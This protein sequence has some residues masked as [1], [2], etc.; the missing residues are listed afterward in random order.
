M[1]LFH[2]F[3]ILSVFVRLVLAMT[4]GGILGYGRS[5][6]NRAAGLRTYKIGR[7]HV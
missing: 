3:N 5:K 6:K 4:S 7:A 1:E 2:E